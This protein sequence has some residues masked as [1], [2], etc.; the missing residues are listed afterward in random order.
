MQFRL[1]SYQWLLYV[2]VAYG[3][4][5]LQDPLNYKDLTKGKSLIQGHRVGCVFLVDTSEQLY[6]PSV[7][8]VGGPSGYIFHQTLGFHTKHNKR[9]EHSS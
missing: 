4:P 8:V 3:P 1:V 7:A 2:I 9:H 5:Q 6:C